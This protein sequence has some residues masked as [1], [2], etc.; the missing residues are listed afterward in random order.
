MSI[1]NFRFNVRILKIKF[2][3]VIKFGVIENT[4]LDMDKQCKFR[5][6]LDLIN[7]TSKINRHICPSN[8][9]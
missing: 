7:V 4:N 8:V 9:F 5:F 3:K 6:V 1:S 2:S